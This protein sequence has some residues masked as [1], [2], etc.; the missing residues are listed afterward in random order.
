[1]KSTPQQQLI[2]WI[3]VGAIIVLAGS[4][5]AFFA[6]RSQLQEK[7]AKILESRI[8]IELNTR[9]KQNLSALK[10]QVD[11]ILKNTETLN[12]AF[13]D[14]SKTFE[15]LQYIE[16]LAE[17]NT[18][19]LT[20]PQLTEPART[21]PDNETTYSVEEKAFHI[22]LAG[23]VPNLMRFLRALE[24]QPAYLLINTVDLRNNSQGSE[25]SLSIEGVIPWH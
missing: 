18:L 4:W 23:K 3:V 25:A 14:R 16:N 2:M 5:F 17:E 9:Q 21:S 1:M 6:L 7:S 20:E 8:S 19:E 15:F 10:N 12:A 11:Q 24:T 13:F 22:D